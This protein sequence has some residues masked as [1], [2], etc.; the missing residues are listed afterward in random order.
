MVN[1]ISR[2]FPPLRFSGPERGTPGGVLP[3]EHCRR[4]LIRIGALAHEASAVIERREPIRKDGFCG[5]SVPI[6]LGGIDGGVEGHTALASNRGVK[7]LVPAAGTTPASRYQARPV[8]SYSRR[9]CRQ[10]PRGA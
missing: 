5:G 8:D 4:G 1:G 9:S 3:R 7:M 10:P 6:P 2:K